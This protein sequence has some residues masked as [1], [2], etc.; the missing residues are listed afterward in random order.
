MLITYSA[1][2]VTIYA[3]NI[4]DFCL[5]FNLTKTFAHF[6]NAKSD[7]LLKCTCRELLQF[8]SLCP[9]TVGDQLSLSVC[10]DVT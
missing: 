5:C 8:V 7:K 2:D 10:I 3:E 1:L 6:L 4:E 9:F